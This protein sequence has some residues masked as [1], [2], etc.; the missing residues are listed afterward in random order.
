M[1]AQDAANARRQKSYCPLRTNLAEV[2]R[3]ARSPAKEPVQ[4]PA[5]GRAKLFRGKTLEPILVSRKPQRQLRIRERAR[6]RISM[7]FGAR[8][9]IAASNS[10]SRFRESLR[11]VER[12]R[13]KNRPDRAEYVATDL[14]EVVVTAILDDT[15]LSVP[16]I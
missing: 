5:A 2:A 11:R 9:C 15:Y 14:C 1:R 13:G 4:V 6:L 16:S 10:A 3:I 12:F 7:V 8:V